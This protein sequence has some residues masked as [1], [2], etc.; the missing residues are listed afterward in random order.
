MRVLRQIGTV[1]VTLPLVII[2]AIALWIGSK[3]KDTTTTL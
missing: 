3:R 1:I 2:Y